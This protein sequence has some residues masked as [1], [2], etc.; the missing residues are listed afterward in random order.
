MGRVGPLSLWVKGVCLW[1]R[2]CQS[3]S[4]C[5]WRRGSVSVS[6]IEGVSLRLWVERGSVS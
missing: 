6:G 2:G 1:D 3:V 5:E 4:V